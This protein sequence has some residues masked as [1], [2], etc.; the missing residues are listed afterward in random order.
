MLGT[1]LIKKVY[2]NSEKSKPYHPIK[3]DST[4]NIKS[5]RIGHVPVRAR[6]NE[7]EEK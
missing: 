4:V 5:L 7:I 3:G 2:L 6:D 1:M